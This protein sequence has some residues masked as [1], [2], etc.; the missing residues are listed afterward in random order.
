MFVQHPL[1][2]ICNE[3]FSCIPHC[4]SPHILCQKFLL[5]GTEFI[6]QPTVDFQL[7]LLVSIF[8]GLIFPFSKNCLL[9][10]QPVGPAQ[11][12]Q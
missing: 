1:T 9:I 3:L 10:L 5:I 12:F 8:I 2:V 11:P 6:D 7:H 4:T